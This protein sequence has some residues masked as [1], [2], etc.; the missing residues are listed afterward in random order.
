MDTRILV[1]EIRESGEMKGKIVQQLPDAIHWQEHK[2]DNYVPI[3]SVKS[4]ITYDGKGP[5]IVLIDYGYKRSLLRYLQSF[6]CKVTVVPYDI[7]P[8]EVKELNP[9]GVLFSNGPGNPEAL[10]AQ[11]PYIKQISSTYPSFGICL[12]HQLLALA[13]GA[14]TNKLT[15][16]HRGVN[17][18]VKH[19][20]TGKV[21]MTSQNHGYEVKLESINHTP[22]QPIY[23]NVNDGSLE[24]MK[25]HT[26]PI[27]SVQFHPEAHAEPLDTSHMFAQFIQEVGECAYATT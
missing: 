20:S 8:E 5:H 14:P 10:Q 27:F 1:K 12:G 11:L 7:S 21:Y 17:H 23:I 19:L 22:F 2:H 6:D 25:H 18:P 4:A 16:G 9:D 3:V 13:Y 26:L 15:F 24:G